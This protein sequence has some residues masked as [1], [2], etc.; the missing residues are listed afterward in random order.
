MTDPSRDHA[1]PAAEAPG[2]FEQ[3]PILPR[4]GIG[5]VVLMAVALPLFFAVTDRVLDLRVLLIIEGAVLG[6]AV[7]V[8]IA[9]LPQT[10]RAVRVDARGLHVR[11]RL[12]VPAGRIGRVHVLSGGDAATWSWPGSRPRGGDRPRL[13]SRQ[14]LYGGLYGWGP[15]VAVEV[16]DRD[17]PTVWLLPSRDTTALAACLEQV[18]GGA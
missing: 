1:A 8:A 12:E 3:G 16:V 6:L 15:A 18:R 11:G 17:D 13:P 9:T 10:H 5:I 7:V 2:V 14:N 4:G